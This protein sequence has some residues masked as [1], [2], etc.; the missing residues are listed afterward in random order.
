MLVY[1]YFEQVL[2]DLIGCVGHIEKSVSGIRY[3]MA[4]ILYASPL[5]KKSY[6]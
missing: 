6:L 2:E 3:G 4:L 5:D 1:Q